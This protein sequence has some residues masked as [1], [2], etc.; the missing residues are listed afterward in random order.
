MQRFQQERF[1]GPLEIQSYFKCPLEDDRADIG[2]QTD[3]SLRKRD[4][5]KENKVENTV[6]SGSSEDFSLF[7]LR[8]RNLRKVCG[9]ESQVV[10]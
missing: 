10:H 5:A 9:F 7:L 8:L 6:L 3:M 1:P 4:G 2:C